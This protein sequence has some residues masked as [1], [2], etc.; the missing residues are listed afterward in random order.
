MAISVTKPMMD[1]MAIRI[2][3]FP[4][5]APCEFAAG[6]T[7]LKRPMK[8]CLGLRK[9]CIE[10]DARKARLCGGIWLAVISIGFSPVNRLCSG[11]L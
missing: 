4:P 1:M 3:T 6:Q 8:R 2:A 10:V 11:R 7:P 9:L 5:L